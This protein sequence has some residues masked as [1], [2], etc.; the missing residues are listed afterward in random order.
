MISE[1]SIASNCVII[2]KIVIFCFYGIM[3]FFVIMFGLLGLGMFLDTFRD[4]TKPK[5][6]YVPKDTDR[7]VLKLELYDE[8]TE[9]T[10]YGILYENGEIFYTNE[11]F[12]ITVQV[13]YEKYYSNY[14]HVDPRIVSCVYQ[15]IGE[16]WLF[17]DIHQFIINDRKYVFFQLNVNW[18]CP[19]DLYVYNEEK[20]CIEKLYEWDS[21]RITGAAPPEVTEIDIMHCSEANHMQYAHIQQYLKS[22]EYN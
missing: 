9:K 13:R 12:E 2:L 10:V 18:V 22:L 1:K 3:L 20:D 11:P 21:V 17:G 8:I 14:N 5:Y 16:H 4:Y 7:Q 19:S 15:E 6:N